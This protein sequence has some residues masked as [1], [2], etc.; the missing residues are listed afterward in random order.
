MRAAVMRNKEIVVDTLPDPVPGSGEVLVKTLACGICGSDLHMLRHAEKMMES[1]RDTGAPFVPNLLADV[2]M[3]HEFCA[4]IVEFGP[5]TLKRIPAGSRVVSMPISFRGGRLQAIGYSEEVPGGYGELM[6]LTE[7][8]LLPVPNGLSTEHAATTEPIAVG[9]HAVAKANVTQRDAALVVGCGPVGLAVIAGLRLAGVET[10]V[11]A[12]YSPMR[13]RLAEHMGASVVVDPKV[14]RPIEAWRKV[15]G[16]KSCVLFECVGVPGVI[17]QLMR[18]A[19]PQSR[20]V[21]AGVCMEDDTIRPTFGINKEL[22]VQFVLGYTPD[23]FARTL[24]A[25]A[26]GA[27]D[28]APMVTGRTGVEGVAESFRTLAN[29][30]AHAKI[31][32]EPWRS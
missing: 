8:L 27:I 26:E 23:E 32:V 2:V 9:V 6:V 3:G 31:L 25:L 17:D 19:P 14:E 7:P 5:N 22:N 13:R 12:D 18:D 11:A 20:I 10:I 29:P 24:T 28:V 21:V 1:M 4:E 16:A 30:E 15:A